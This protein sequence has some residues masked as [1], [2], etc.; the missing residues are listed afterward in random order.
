MSFGEPLVSQHVNM[1]DGLRELAFG[2]IFLNLITELTHR[3]ETPNYKGLNH[4]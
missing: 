1:D 3:I 4:I 2:G